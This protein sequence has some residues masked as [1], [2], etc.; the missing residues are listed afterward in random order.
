MPTRNELIS[1]LLMGAA[2][3]DRRL[4]GSEY[5]AVK[6]ALARALGVEQVP[7]VLLARLEWFDPAKFDAARTAAELALASDVEKRQ[8]LELVASV[9]DA[10]EVL[11]LDEDS[12]LRKVAEAIGLP[13]ELYADLV[14][15]DLSVESV[16]G[17]GQA[18]LGPP[19]KPSRRPPPLPSNS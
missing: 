18:L 12:Y 4:D 14:I 2:F 3:A 7:P 6:R 9:S 17:A 8:L 10:D 16:R 5:E 1:D 11:D 19:P 13:R 15:Q